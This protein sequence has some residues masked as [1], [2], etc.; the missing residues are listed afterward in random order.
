MGKK[1]KKWLCVALAVVMMASALPLIAGAIAP[2][3]GGSVEGASSS[4]QAPLKVEIRSN[5]DKYSLLGKMEFIATIT[6]TSGAT[7][8]NISAQALLG[9]S[10]RP[11]KNGSQFTATKASLAPGAS[12]S[13]KYYADLSGLKGLDNL[14]LPFFW[15]SSLFH[16]GKATIGNVNGEV[17]C[18]EASKAVGLS[19][20]SGG[21]YDAS[22]RVKV[23]CGESTPETIDFEITF[24]FQK[25]I[26]QVE[27]YYTDSK[28]HVPDEKIN[29]LMSAI[30]QVFSISKSNGTIKE[31]NVDIEN[32]SIFGTLS[33]GMGYVYMP[34]IKGID[35]V[36]TN[37]RIV[38]SQPCDAGYENEE[39]ELVSS[40]VDGSATKIA[41]LIDTNS[42]YVYTF[43]SDDT[44]T[45]D[46]WNDDEISLESLKTLSDFKVVIWH[47]HG[48]YNKSIHSFLQ[49][50]LDFDKQ[51]FLWDPI[52]YAKHISY[53]ADYLSG[54]I[55][56][57]SDGQMAVT[58]KF[59]EKYLGSMDNALVYLGACS[60]GKD[61]VLAKSFIS[62]GASSVFANSNPIHTE[63]NLTMIREVLN[64]MTTK[65]QE[66]YYDTAREALEKAKVINGAI[67]NVILDENLFRTEVLLFENEQQQNYRFLNRQKLG[68][69]SAIAR[70]N[71]STPIPGVN[72]K[73]INEENTVVAERTTDSVGKVNFTL[74]VGEYSMVFSKAGYRTDTFKETIV[75]GEPLI[76]DGIIMEKLSGSDFATIT[77]TVLEQGTNAPL[78]GVLVQ[79]TKTGTTALMD[80]STTSASG[81]FMLLVEANATYSLKFTKAGYNEQTL[82][83]VSDGTAI[84][85]VVMVPSSE[86]PFA[87]GTGTPTDPYLI[88]TPA[89]LNNVRNDLTA[90][91]KMI[92]DIDLTE[93][94]NWEP[95]G[96]TADLRY[97]FNGVFD[98]NGYVVRNITVENV[99]TGITESTMWAGVGLFGY[100]SGTVKNTGMVNSKVNARAI[101][102]AYAGGIAGYCTSSATIINCYNMG[103]ITATGQTAVAGGI[104]GGNPKISNCYNTGKVSASASIKAYAGGIVGGN[105]SSPGFGY[106]PAINVNNSYNTGAVSATVT[107]SYY[108]IAFA[109][110]I[111]GEL[112]LSST[113]N[114]C[115]NMG[116]VSASAPN[117]PEKEIGAGGI[118]GSNIT[119][120]ISNSYYLNN[121]TNAVGMNNGIL[122]NVVV[123]T[124]FQ[125]KQQA[126]FVGFD[127]ATVWTIS[128]AINNGYPYLRGMQP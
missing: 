71:D 49:I 46:N 47:G 7:V 59:F 100:L 62:K 30:E 55:I 10:L 81:G 124:D 114:N 61:D 105:S 115:Y 6:N 90:H 121:N 126:S 27:E 63:Y 26:K 113:T 88:S 84:A 42:E 120:L 40:C 78:S 23:W 73:A 112:P 4:G 41:S 101:V 127:F 111:V 38:T 21:Q 76:Y 117:A 45:D 97:Y 122:T 92:N 79:A 56:A 85:D 65:D 58:P 19:S 60:S 28:G 12:F 32:I 34:P 2:S 22:T 95:I 66:G 104:A 98:G 99:I 116:S 109:G 17:D 91:Y 75:Y 43:F 53:T 20:L 8:E 64:A 9:G 108:S 25:S 70:E 74:P 52:Y 44:S 67:D 35:S 13:F 96:Y 110:G 123:L 31:Y 69:Y 14:L 125:M 15:I 29:E 18:I 80:S 16:G 24:D 106:A 11:L 5:K 93:W 94:G 82:A 3:A 107:D 39:Q 54:R 102:E 1:I 37:R 118:A 36:S 51:K 48:G 87:G 86:L 72:V 128:P 33:N 103:E 83:N 89:Q 77:G 119:S 68:E 57:T 50:G